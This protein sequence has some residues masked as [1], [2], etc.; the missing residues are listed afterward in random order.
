MSHAVHRPSSARVSSRET[1][2]VSNKVST[3]RRVI[4]EAILASAFIVGAALLMWGSRFSEN[5]VHDQ[6]S[7]QNITFPAKGP[8]LDP[9]TYP[10]L[11]RYAG[12]KVDSGEKARAYADQFIKVHLRDVAGGKTY[13]EVSAEAMKS[14]TAVA[15]AKANKAANVSTLEAKAAVLDGQTQTL[16]RGETLR[17]LLLYAWGWSL[18]GDIAWWVSIAAGIVGVVLFVLASMGADSMWSRR[19]YHITD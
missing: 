1:L 6:L 18:L 8:A 13:S 2:W 7:D 15:T 3:S 12:Q 9:K 17:G 11:Q 10:G 4:V 14:H 5:M 16:F 19:Q